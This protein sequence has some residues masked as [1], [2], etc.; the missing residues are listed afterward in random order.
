MAAFEAHIDNLK[1]GA[2]REAGY[3]VEALPSF[4]KSPLR[5]VT[6]LYKFVTSPVPYHLVQ[7]EQAP[8]I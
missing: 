6:M 1:K 5:Q 8:T 2:F 3:K 4:Y 7:D